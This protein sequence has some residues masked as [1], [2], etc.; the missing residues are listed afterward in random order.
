MSTGAAAVTGVGRS[1]QG[2][3]LGRPVVSLVV[4]AARQAIADAGLEIDDVDAM[5][6]EASYAARVAPQDE[7]ASELG[8]GRSF[9]SLATGI[10][11][12]G[13]V[14]TLAAAELLIGTG[15][16]RHVLCYFGS[17]FGSSTGGPYDFPV[18]MDAKKNYEAPHGWFGQPLYFAA[19]AE[20]YAAEFGLAPEA[21][22]AVAVA[23]REGALRTDDAV[24]RRPL[25][26]D[27]YWDEPPIVGRF[28]RA[29]CSVISDGAFAWVVSAGDRAGD[30]PHVPVSILGC[31][32][33]SEPGMS[34]STYWTQ[35]S[36]FTTTPCAESAAQAFAAAGVT[37][38][39]VDVAQIYDCFS[40]STIVQLEDAGFCAK[41]EGAAFVAEGALRLGGRLP[42][43]THG[44]LLAH[45][46][47][48]GAAHLVE[49]VLQLRGQAEG[50]QVE[51]AEI[52]YLAG[53]GLPE[54]ASAVLARGRA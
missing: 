46:F 24:L 19:M 33:A 50:R 45:S 18:G 5:V 42:T 4:D 25:T 15:R 49:A 40:I 16:H 21:L 44:G 54:H 34:S 20:R 43:N 41:G 38:D 36:R 48:V 30:G 14:S 53:L 13:V 10:G 1:A 17:D 26:V 29:D 2:R 23:A 37:P 35:R 47:T 32:Q 7:V 31:G 12:A 9:M 52:A 8:H 28:R 3:S 39:D 6:V 22:A 51:S 27:D 11:G